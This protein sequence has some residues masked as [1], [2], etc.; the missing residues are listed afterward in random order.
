[1]RCCTLSHTCSPIKCT[2]HVLT[3]LQVCA[4]EAMPDLL[5][6]RLGC[7]KDWA[8]LPVQGAMETTCVGEQAVLV[9]VQPLLSSQQPQKGPVARLA[10]MVSFEGFLHALS[11]V[12]PHYA[13]LMRI[14]SPYFSSTPCSSQKRYTF[15]SIGVTL[16]CWPA[17]G[18]LCRSLAL[19]AQTKASKRHRRHMHGVSNISAVVWALYR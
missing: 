8:A 4:G 15:L 1:M 11:R 17:A 19:P 7:W 9:Q 14:G 12:Q 10:A 18:M 3:L 2:C 13:T 5:H 16:C 6:N